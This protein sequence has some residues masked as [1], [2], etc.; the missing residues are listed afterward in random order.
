[1]KVFRAF[2]IAM[3]MAIATAGVMPIESDAAAKKK[4]TYT[5]EQRKKLYAEALKLCRKSG[6][7]VSRA[8]VN[9]TT[10][11]VTCWYR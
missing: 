9:W 11:K 7:H 3:A 8:D 5:A 4:K 10:L 6:Y 2:S 1:M